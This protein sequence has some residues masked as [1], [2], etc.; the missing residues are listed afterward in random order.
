[1]AL[2]IGPVPLRLGESPAILTTMCQVL[3]PAHF[4]DEKTEVLRGE[5]MAQ[6]HAAIKRAPGFE[7]RADLTLH[8]A[9]LSN[10]ALWVLAFIYP[11]FCTVWVCTCPWPSSEWGPGASRDTHVPHRKHCGCFRQMSCRDLRE[12]PGHPHLS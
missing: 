8:K 1:M 5:V 9:S 11:C 6:W 12:S 7:P 3:L 2:G 10:P 4:T